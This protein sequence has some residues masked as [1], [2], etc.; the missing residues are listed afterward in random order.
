MIA[1]VPPRI[2]E[3]LTVHQ[4]KPARA[5]PSRSDL[6]HVGAVVALDQLSRARVIRYTDK[7]GYGLSDGRKT[8]AY[9]LACFYL[10]D[11]RLTEHLAA[12]CLD[13]WNALNA[14]PL[15]D[16]VVS[17]VLHNAGKYARGAA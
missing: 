10:A 2:L 13:A 4:V 7:V 6:P 14:P 3:L 16:G 12:H 5:V 9:R 11:V 1:S 8:A 15:P 17:S